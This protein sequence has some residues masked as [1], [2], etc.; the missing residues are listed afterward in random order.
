MEVIYQDP[1]EEQN[2]KRKT[3]LIRH[4]IAIVVGIIVGVPFVL[5]AFFQLQSTFTR[6]SDTIPRD[7]VIAETTDSSAT[8]HWTT[9]QASQAVIRYGTQ[10]ETLDKLAPESELVNDHTMVIEDLQPGTTYYFNIQIEGETYTNGGI[11]WYFT[12]EGAVQEEPVDQPQRD[13][14]CPVTTDCNE[15]QELLGKG[16]STADYLRCL[17]NQ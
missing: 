11:P 9:D 14:R 5:Y 1:Q 12:T 3:R 2:R 17:R 8:I 16:C 6:A 4:I 15:I 10:Q 13:S 7:V